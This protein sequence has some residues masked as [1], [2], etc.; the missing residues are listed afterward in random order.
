MRHAGQP[1]DP[2][3]LLAERTGK[4]QEISR[5]VAG[6]C[7]GTI[8]VRGHNPHQQQNQTAEHKHTH[9][10]TQAKQQPQQKH[11][12]WKHLIRTGHEVDLKEQLYRFTYPLM[13][14]HN[15]NRNVVQPLLHEFP[16]SP[17]PPTETPRTRAQRPRSP[18]ARA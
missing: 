9:A 7:K 15:T 10:H 16:H 3:R 8:N 5:A 11:E 17:I 6:S 13:K 14:I 2:L 1:Q 4:N 12:Q 18:G